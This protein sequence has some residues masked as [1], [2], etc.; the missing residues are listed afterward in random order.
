MR[1]VPKLFR[2]KIVPSPITLESD[3]KEREEIEQAMAQLNR[4][5]RLVQL[6]EVRKGG[7]WRSRS[8]L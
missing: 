8:S 2:R 4:L 1:W 7:A 5:E 6:H 3:E